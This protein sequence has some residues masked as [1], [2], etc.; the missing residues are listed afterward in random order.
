MG[1]DTTQ[2]VPEDGEPH[3]LK[4]LA[5]EQLVEMRIAQLKGSN[6]QIPPSDELHRWAEKIC[7]G[8]DSGTGP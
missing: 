1:T 7:D 6:E 5:I 4:Q 2:P 3:S 8:F